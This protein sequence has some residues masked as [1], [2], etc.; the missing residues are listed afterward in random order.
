MSE[1]SS[2]SGELLSRIRET[3]AARHLASERF[4]RHQKLSLWTL[5]CLSISL[6]LIPLVQATEIPISI[7]PTYLFATQA[8]LAVLVLIYALL[9]GL[10]SFVSQRDEMRRSALELERLA[11]KLVANSRIGDTDYHTLSKEYFAILDRY[12]E[13]ERVDGLLARL[14]AAPRESRGRAGY[15]FLWGRAQIMKL[16]CCMHYLLTLAFTAFVLCAL[17]ASMASSRP[18]SL[19]HLSSVGKTIT[20]WIAKQEG[21]EAPRRK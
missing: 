17:L 18:R 4:A 5:V 6:L 11:Q 14:G 1:P 20:E 7:S 21:V 9:V 19:P 16:G 12:D 15:L 3:A 13:H 10:E 2:R 8:L